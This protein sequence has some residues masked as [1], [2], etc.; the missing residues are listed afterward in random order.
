MTEGKE[1]SRSTPADTVRQTV[2]QA[3]Q[4]TFHATERQAQFTRERAQELVDEL[5]GTASRIRD[6]L[7]ELRPTSADDFRTLR[8]RVDELEARVSALEAGRRQ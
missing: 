7:E 4:A 8:A 6:A 5:A 2:D 1:K 3:V